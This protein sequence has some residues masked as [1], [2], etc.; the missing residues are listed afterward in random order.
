VELLN[1]PLCPEM[2]LIIQLMT[3]NPTQ[4]LH[5]VLSKTLAKPPNVL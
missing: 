4:V 5:Q 3:R 2:A 1:Q